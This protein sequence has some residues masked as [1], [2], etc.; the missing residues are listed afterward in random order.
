MRDSCCP[1]NS[2][3]NTILHSLNVFFASS[4]V[5]EQK[6]YVENLG[7]QRVFERGK[8]ELENAKERTNMNLYLHLKRLF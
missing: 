6:N 1:L 7:S 8:E 2:Y 4:F 3:V 5:I